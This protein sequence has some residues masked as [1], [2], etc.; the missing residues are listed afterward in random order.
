MAKS[1]ISIANNKIAFLKGNREVKT[2][3]SLESSIR[4]HGIFNALSVI[5]FSE[6]KGLGVSLVDPLTFEDILTPSDDIYV[7]LDGQHRFL[8]AQKYYL[9]M[10]EDKAAGDNHVCDTIPVDILTLED[11]R[12]MTP[13]NWISEMNST[14]VNWKSPDYIKS[15]YLRKGDDPLL[16]AIKYLQDFGLAISVIS[17]FLFF[18]KHVL[19][20]KSLSDYLDGKRDFSEANPQRGLEIFRMLVEKGFSLK[21]LKKRYIIE[22]IIKKYTRSPEDYFEIL[23]ALRKV[24]KETINKIENEMTTMDYATG[25]IG[26]V[27]LDSVS[28]VQ[29][30]DNEGVTDTCDVSEFRLNDSDERYKENLD[31]IEKKSN[32][33][34]TV[35]RCNLSTRKKKPSRKI[36][37]TIQAC[38]YDEII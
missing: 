4:N 19:T 5:L 25:Q 34:T 36:R 17:L 13:L 29:S 7:I 3:K 9:E 22:L 24:S 16:K 30:D 28:D 26:V 32:E 37:K 14:H 35:R 27:I 31:Y 2:N 15:A 12:G 23:N 33:I 10:Q 6:V 11:L 8:C 38:T 18:D 20:P 21:L 1:T